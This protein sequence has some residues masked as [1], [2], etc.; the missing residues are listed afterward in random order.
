VVLPLQ[1]LPRGGRR[2][3]D[4]GRHLAEADEHDGAVRRGERT[5]RAVR[6]AAELVEV[7]DE[8]EPPRG[9]RQVADIRN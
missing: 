3:H 9:G 4:D 6:E 2:G 5:K 7:V 1:H 8:R